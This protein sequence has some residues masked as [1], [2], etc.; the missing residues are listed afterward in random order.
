MS[1]PTQSALSAQISR[2]V[3]RS[4]H[5]AGLLTSDFRYPEHGPPEVRA[6][7]FRLHLLLSLPTGTKLF[8]RQYVSSIMDQYHPGASTP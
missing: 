3:A 5:S 7:H 4:S 1:T 6:E 8:P 2:H